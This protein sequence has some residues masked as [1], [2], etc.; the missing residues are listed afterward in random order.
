M[1]T[2]A[3]VHRLQTGQ[4]LP[5]SRRSAGPVVLSEGELLVQEPAS[6]LG[7]TVVVPPAVRFVAPAV[8]PAVLSGSAVA[9]RESTVVV[10]EPAPLFASVISCVPWAWCRPS[11][12]GRAQ[13]PGAPDRPRSYGG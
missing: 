3:R 11:D 7:G 8:L 6:W 5:V 10:Q 2:Q 9:V 12:A 13:R 4:A 1:N